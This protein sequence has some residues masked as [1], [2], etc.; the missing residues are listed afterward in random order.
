V[1]EQRPVCSKTVCADPYVCPL[2]RV[3]AGT[4]VRIRRLDAP[5]EVTVRLRELG[6]CEQQRIKLLSRHPNLICLVC[7]ARLGI[8]PELADNILVEP[9]T[10]QGRA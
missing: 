6:F 7:N 2:S 1:T 8:S 9:I 3:L 4:A 5:P 10:A